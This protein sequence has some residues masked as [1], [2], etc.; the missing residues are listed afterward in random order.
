MIAGDRPLSN[1]SWL[2]GEVH[3]PWHAS[4]YISRNSRKRLSTSS[5]C[6][7]C[8]FLTRLQ[9]RA[10]ILVRFKVLGTPFI[11]RYVPKLC[12]EGCRHSL[13]LICHRAATLVCHIIAPSVWPVLLCRQCRVAMVPQC[14][15]PVLVNCSACSIRAAHFRARRPSTAGSQCHNAQSAGEMDLAGFNYRDCSPA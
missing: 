6:Y 5:S 9:E 15:G 4:A 13:T 8:T 14:G 1:T 7:F 12:L 2:A 11:A 10:C 3:Q